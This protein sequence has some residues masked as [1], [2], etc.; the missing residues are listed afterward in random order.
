MKKHL[1]IIFVLFSF[2]SIS[3]GSYSVDNASLPEGFKMKHPRLPYPDADFLARLKD[4]PQGLAGYIK[5]AEEFNPE[6]PRNRDSVRSLL[7]A[8]IVTKNNKYLGKIEQLAD[9][10]FSN[11][12]FSK[13]DPLAIIYDWLYDDLPPRVREKF[14]KHL[15]LATEEAIKHYK[16]IRV[17]PYND[18]GY[19][20]LGDAFIIGAIA[21]GPDHPKGVE[22]LKFAEDV[23]FNK[24]LPVWKQTIGAGGGW[25]EGIEYLERG[26][27]SLV[28]SALSSWG[29]AT[30]RDLFKE[31]PD[32]ENFIYF[33]I[34]ANRP[35]Y[36]PVRIGDVAN[37]VRISYPDVLSLS[38]VYNN[39]Y[40]R[41]AAREFVRYGK[42]NPSG[43]YPSGWPWGEPDSPDALIKNP[44]DLP[45]AH[46][47]N[48]WGVVA[49]RSDWTEDA[50]YATFRVGDNLWS[51]QNF[52][53]GSF[54]IYH[55]G[56]LA[57][58][59]GTYAADYN[60]EHHINYA[61]QTIAHNCV[62]ITDPKDYYPDAKRI[63]P[64]DGGQ[65]RVGSLYHRSPDDINDWLKNKEDYE[66]GD[67]IVFNSA[68]EYDFVIGDVTTAYNNTNSNKGDY[69]NRTKRVNNYQRFFL[70]LRPDLFVIIDYVKGVNKQFKKHWL[71]HSINEPEIN[72]GIVKITRTDRV[73][74]WDI[75]NNSLKYRSP[76][77]KYY[78][79]YGRLFSKTVYPENFDIVK[80]G[81]PGHE[82]E[83]NGVNYNKDNKGKEIVPNPLS[84]PG[85]PGAW[86]IEVSSQKQQK[87]DLFIHVLYACDASI[88]SMLDIEKIEAD[89][90]I[91]VQIKDKDFD[92]I[93]LF[94]NLDNYNEDVKEVS[95]SYD[96]SV[97]PIKCYLFGMLENSRFQIEKETVENIVKVKIKSGSGDFISNKYGNI[98]FK[99]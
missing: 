38:T 67:I 72:E 88:E 23:L 76:D 93:A 61:M 83:I 25:H 85:E 80:I 65:R 50:V 19:I 56:A 15:V 78:Q 4:N 9:A 84:G 42:N 48:G 1:L 75:W 31:N 32:L 70:Y 59:S 28:Y 39:P 89:S 20:R 41:W 46:H 69:R 17:S 68:A 57:I 35:D 64:N 10:S 24:Y 29:S 36:T 37:C 52:D 94:P 18:M 30:G 11:F 81:G 74:N 86:R 27:G 91:G 62:T 49:M 2:V 45:L 26:L 99:L 71:L 95:F 8:Y 96:I 60:S 7:V 54:T 82:F 73:K 12:W 90:M 92:R 14:Q 34:Y 51:H 55:K 53:S 58:D 98:N 77:K 40:G 79:Y 5:A 13:V 6:N 87:D 22:Y 47:F 21:L 63:L 66:M 44:D 33:P 97:K 16:E 3:C 43:F